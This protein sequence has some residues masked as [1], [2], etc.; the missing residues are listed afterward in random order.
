MNG[1]LTMSTMKFDQAACNYK[2]NILLTCAG[3]RHYLASY[4]SQ[5]LG[6]SGRVVGTDMDLTAPALQACAAAHQVPGVFEAGYLDALKKVILEENIQMVFSLNDLEVGLLAENR[7]ELE[8]ETGATF[9]VPPVQTLDTCADKWRTFE[10][11]REIGVAAPETFLTVAG[12]VQALEL[13]R[14]QFPLIIKPRWG[15]ASIGLHVVETR[16]DLERGVEAC[17]KAVAKSALSSPGAEDS[18]IIQEIIQGPEYGVDILYGHQHNYIGFTA[19]RKLAMRAGETDKA[20]TVPP[21]PF[22]GIVSKIAGALPHRGNMDC[23]ILE[24]DGRLYLL[25]LNPR[26]GGGYPFT[27]LAGADH[28]RLLL[29]DYAGKDLHPYSYRLG[30]AFAKCDTLV[31]VP[32]Q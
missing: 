17:R 6:Q 28:V 19:K 23:D 25:E 16:E 21:E 4:F 18:V 7:A 1:L 9:Y 27:H 12:A 13:E 8:Q 11:A 5:A 24:R 15:S 14:V 29:D 20:I 10:F 30:E 31:R 22:E 2:V 3:R 26:F 32:A